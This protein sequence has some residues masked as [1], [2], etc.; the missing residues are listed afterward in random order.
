M[1]DYKSLIPSSG[2]LGT[3]WPGSFNITQGKEGKTSFA[4]WTNGNEGFVQQTFLGASIRNFNINIGFGDTSS[5]LSVSLV[6]DEYNKSDK[7]PLGEGD[8][9]YHNGE[10]DNFIPP[11][12]G[13]PVFFKFGK[14]L[15][16]VKE[17][18]LRYLDILYPQYIGEKGYHPAVR[19]KFKEFLTSG[20]FDSTPGPHYI[21]IKEDQDGVRTWEDREK[22]VDIDLLKKGENRGYDHILFGGIL[23]NYTEN[24]SQNGNPLFD[25]QVVDPREILS[26][27]QLILGNYADT[28]FDNQNM[29]NV[30]GFLEYDP[31]DKLKTALENDCYDKWIFQKR[32]MVTG[33]DIGKVKY[34]GRSEYTKEERV[35]STSKASDALLDIYE[36]KDFL[37]GVTFGSAISILEGDVLPDPMPRYFP[38][39]GEG[40]ARRSDLGIPWF[41]VSQ[42]L[43][44]MWEEYGQLPKEYKDAGFGGEIDF[45]GFNYIVDFSGF[46]VDKIPDLYFLDFEQIDLLS[47]CQEMCDIISHDLVVSLQPVVEHPAFKFLYG[48]NKY[49]IEQGLYEKIVHGVIRV[50]AIDRSKQPSYGAIQ[51]YLDELSARNI[52]VENQDVGF[53]LSNV[54]TDKLVAGAQEVNMYFFSSQCDRDVLEYRKKLYNVKDERHQDVVDNQ[55]SLEASLKQQILPFYGFIGDNAVT[56]PR[57]FGSYQQVMLDTS[58]LDAIGVGNYYV[59]TEMEMRAALVSYEK[60]KN[61]LLDYNDLY[62]EE[63]TEG[64]AFYDNLAATTDAQIDGFTNLPESFGLG[65]LTNRQFGVSVPRCVFNSDRGQS[66]GMT[67]DPENFYP[68]DLTYLDSK[69][70]TSLAIDTEY[71]LPRS[72]CSPP[73]GYPLYYKRAERIGIPEA[74]IIRLG[75]IKNNILTKIQDYRDKLAKDSDAVLNVDKQEADPNRN[76]PTGSDNTSQP[77]GNQPHSAAVTN[78]ELNEDTTLLNDQLNCAQKRMKEIQ[79]DWSEVVKNTGPDEIVRELARIESFLER[80]EKLMRNISK[81]SRKAEKNAKKVYEFIKSVAEEN[82]GKKFLVKIPKYTN[83]NFSTFSSINANIELVP[84]LD[85]EGNEI[86]GVLVDGGDVGEKILET[87]GSPFGFP[88]KPVHKTGNSFIS[89]SVWLGK[90]GERRFNEYSSRT[91]LK[92]PYQRYLYC[93]NF[94]KVQ[95]PKL[96]PI[97]ITDP[98]IISLYS[99][100]PPYVVTLREDYKN[101]DGGLKVHWNPVSDKWEYNYSP[102]PQGGFFDFDLFPRNLNY[103]AISA[104]AVSETND[105]NSIPPIQ[106]QQLAPKDLTSFLSENGRLSAYVRFNDSQYLDFSQV[107][108]DS[109]YQEVLTK[110]GIVPDI[111]DDL[112]NV[113]PEQPDTM[114]RIRERLLSDGDYKKPKAVAYVKCSIDSKFYMAPKILKDKVDLLLP[115]ED[116]MVAPETYVYGRRVRWQPSF[117]KPE[118]VQFTDPTDGKEKVGCA[119]AVVSPLFDVA[120]TGGYDETRYRNQDYMRRYHQETESWKVVTNDE[121][122]DPDHV[123]ALITIPGRISSTEE[124]RFVDSI[125][126]SANTNTIKS[127]LTQ[128]VVRGPIGFDQP[129]P[130]INEQI[131]IDCEEFSFSELHNAQIAQREAKRNYNIANPD[132]NINYAAPSPI[133][134]DIVALPLMSNERCYGPWYSSY[135]FNSDYAFSGIKPVAQKQRYIDIGGKSE[136]I[137]D[138]NLAPW[139]YA[140]Y[141]LMNEAGKLKSEFSNSL[142][143]FSE[144]GGFVFPDMPSGIIAGRSLKEDGP[145]ITSISLDISNS[146]K[147]TVKLDLY[148]SR[149]GK[150]QKQKEIAISQMARERQRI[151]DDRNKRIRQGIRGSIKGQDIIGSQARAVFAQSSQI[152][153]SLERGETVYNNLYAS[154]DKQTTPYKLSSVYPESQIEDPIISIDKYTLSSATQTP[155]YLEEAISI[156]DEKALQRI[157]W[158]STAGGNY[159]TFFHG[160]DNSSYSDYFPHAGYIDMSATLRRTNQ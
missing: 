15:A 18:W 102:E 12:V 78:V 95:F 54:V 35:A 68:E 88:A 40:F 9:V 37:P 20:T 33:E 93:E 125:F 45:R 115:S 96:M 87:I 41:R 90:E 101:S 44:A 46:P 94:E 112:E 58:N 34:V 158:Q 121:E 79:D 26:N 150:L 66:F 6:S 42:A 19:P 69:P 122:L 28:T 76:Q 72:P 85:A 56:I 61:F 134:P 129:A 5:T 154:V 138:E 57:G 146:V 148:S 137:K 8:D 104:I 153:S 43:A 83:N 62:I 81:N 159:N 71:N 131:P 136:F 60:W 10:Y 65:D 49:Y 27:V 55:W 116:K 119:Q 31:S 21:L 50:E 97:N 130:F 123:W 2:D 29:I 143:L 107:G 24:K 70:S 47:L 52:Y 120:S 91:Q 155:Q 135:N 114:N 51:K 3:H 133:Y 99:T 22:L 14:N 142:M 103:N 118:V 100:S 17:S 106:M 16:S 113:N 117:S 141:Q 98:E 108:A 160:A 151:I 75:N 23:Q 124:K 152:Y 11:P 110:D 82:L 86:P 48:R 92:F 25:V 127:I 109:V 73:Y 140:G 32:V 53:E 13:S 84:A 144:R 149:F 36:F 111:M 1:E 30:F 67:V 139:N 126:S 105:K 77:A 74:G 156:D 4:D 38:I 128:D 80:N 39:T 63:L 145:I 59:A 132:L 157:K 147:T 64:K 89:S 7:K